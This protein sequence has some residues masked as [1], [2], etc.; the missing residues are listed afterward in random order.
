ME[1]ERKFLVKNDTW[2]VKS[3]STTVITQFYLTGKDQFPSIRLRTAGGKGYLTLKYA[4]VSESILARDEFEYSIPVEDI[5]AQMDHATGSIIRKTRH[6]VEGP[7]NKIWEVDVFDSPANIPVIAELELESLD[8]TFILPNWIG[9]EVSS[10]RAYS[11]L[12]MSFR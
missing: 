10:D 4:S 8:A 9:K 7:D 5:E 2:K 6:I 1:I 12:A 11:N 3:L